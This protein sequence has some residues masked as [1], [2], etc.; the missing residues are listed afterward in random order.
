[1]KD[2]LT[3]DPQQICVDAVMTMTD[4]GVGQASF[5]WQDVTHAQNVGTAPLTQG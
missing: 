4:D 5:T 3:D 1:M 2:D